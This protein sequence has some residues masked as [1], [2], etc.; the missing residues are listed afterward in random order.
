VLRL[1]ATR[2]AA[3]FLTLLAASALIFLTVDLLPGD[4][5]TA[6][7]GRDAAS[8]PQAVAQLREEYGLDRPIL[9]RYLDWVS[10]AVRFEFGV[11]PANRQPVADLIGP[12]LKRTAVLLGVSLALIFPLALLVGTVSALHRGS[13]VDAGLQVSMLVL[14]SLPSF[15]VGIALIVVFSL[16]WHLL[17]AVSLGLTPESLVLPIATLVL[18]WMPFTA[19]M[20]RAGVVGALDSD[21][22]QMARLK[23]LSEQRVIRSHVLPNSLVPAIQAFALTAAGMPAGIVIVEYLFG[24]QGIG[25]F[26]IDAVRARDV[27]TVE[28]ISLILVAVYVVANLL[29]DIATTLLTPRLR[30]A[31]LG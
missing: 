31:E 24:F 28:A 23:G 8:D 14:A 13:L 16:I 12:R 5:A 22:A 30:T 2:L 17:P 20:V 15:M 27:A 6:F 1:V 3:G 18:G 10:G 21:Y 26:L 4:T 7:L 25:V 11:S 29:S 9:V 19:R